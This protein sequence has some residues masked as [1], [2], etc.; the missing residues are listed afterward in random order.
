M[1]CVIVYNYSIAATFNFSGLLAARFLLGCFEAGVAPAV[2]LLL[3]FWYQRN[4]MA[5]R[6]SIFFGSSTLAGAFGGI[7]AW[8]I[9]GHMDGVQ[10]MASWRWLFLIEGLPTILLGILCL[11]FLPNYPDTANT[12][13]WL[14]PEEK[15]LAIRRV[16]VASDDTTFSKKQ[17]VAVFK[18]YQNAFYTLIYISVLV[19]ISSYST[20]LPTIIRDM[21]VSSL[22][23]QLLTIPPY[24]VACCCLFA[25]AWYSDHIQQ[26]GFPAALCFLVTIIGY[27]FLL[28]GEH[29]ALRYC[30]A[31]FVASGV[32]SAIPVVL[33][34]NNNNNFGHTKRGVSLGLMN[35]VA[36]CFG[37]LGSHI[38]RNE[39][40]PF[41][42][43]GHAICLAFAIFAFVMIAVLRFL[44]KR[45]N[46]RRDELQQD[47]ATYDVELYDRH[48]A[49]R[50]IP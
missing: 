3:S 41:Y 9:I 7:F 39:D 13:W 15:E 28:V 2:P 14:T 43:P 32:Y 36:Q 18:D 20:F 23:A 46:R 16:P 24:I 31:I 37:I 33:S 19:C 47:H 6:I 35:G 21:G 5:G 1:E 38:Y 44:L 48:P 25:V 22:K 27:V 30:G 11:M 8:A 12:K 26:R 45:E 42:R 29:L 10:G 34:W 4:E 17:F 40:A 50:Y 49:F